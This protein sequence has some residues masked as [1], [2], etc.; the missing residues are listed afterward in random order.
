MPQRQGQPVS[1]LH[2]PE[3]AI[4]CALSGVKR[5]CGFA[6]SFMV[7]IRLDLH[8]AVIHP[9]RRKMS[10]CV[11]SCGWL[12]RAGVAAH[13]PLSLSLR[14]DSQKARPCPTLWVRFQC[15]AGKVSDSRE[16]YA[17][18]RRLGDLYAYIQ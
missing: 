17:G 10:L 7:Y 4:P 2:K 13:S 5:L 14:R 12:T 9:F 3:G 6:A 16:L 11:S 18:S 1:V 15:F 8:S